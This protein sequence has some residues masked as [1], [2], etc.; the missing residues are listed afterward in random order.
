MKLSRAST[1]A[2]YGLSYLASQPARRFVPLSEI[3]K[4]C[5]LPEQRLVKIFQQL[6]RA[7][8]LRSSRGVNGGFTLA[9]PSREV[10]LLHVIELV[11]GPIGQADCLLLG[12]KCDYIE[13]DC[14]INDVWHRAQEQML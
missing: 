7:G 13:A 4:W 2:L 3:R 9:K 5:G 8:I 14:P 1:Y 12:G 6:V 11:D 10:S